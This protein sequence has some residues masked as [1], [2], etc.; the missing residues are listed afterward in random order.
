MPVSFIQEEHDTKYPPLR[1]L[2]STMEMKKGKLP[3]AWTANKVFCSTNRI[4]PI[5]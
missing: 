5:V 3:K 1:V 2:L 4:E